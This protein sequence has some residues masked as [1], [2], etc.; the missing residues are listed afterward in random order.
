MDDSVD[1]D[2]A[3]RRALWGKFINM[4]Q[5][6]VAPDYV[7]CSKQVEAK[8]VQKAKEIVKEWYG[9]NPENSPDLCRIVSDKHVA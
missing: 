2:A 3:A 7:L 8:F 5:T 6:C 1:M 9:E 4:G